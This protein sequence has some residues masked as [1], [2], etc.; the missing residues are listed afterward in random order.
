MP[1]LATAVSAESDMPTATPLPTA[2]LVIDRPESQQA[3]PQQLEWWRVRPAAIIIALVGVIVIL[4]CVGL[5]FPPFVPTRWE[6]V[7]VTVEDPIFMPKVNQLGNQG[8]E[9]VSARRAVDGG[10]I[11]GIGASAK[12]EM[13]F[14]RKRSW[15]R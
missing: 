6:Y 2:E 4:T 1:V 15:W 12:Y 7:I 10:G 9:L 13:I 3:K 5:P 8:W 14:K 11:A